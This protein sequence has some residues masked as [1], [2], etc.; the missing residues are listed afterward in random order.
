MTPEYIC[1]LKTGTCACDPPLLLPRPQQVSHFL[2]TGGEDSVRPA[3]AFPGSQ[4]QFP[5]PGSQGSI[6]DPLSWAPGSFPRQ[7]RPGPLLP[8]VPHFPTRD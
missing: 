5:N 1:F 6:P 8:L 3:L 4:E 2:L 7:G